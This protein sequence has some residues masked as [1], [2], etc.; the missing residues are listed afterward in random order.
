MTNERMSRQ[1]GFWVVGVLLAVQPAAWAADYGPGGE[2]TVIVPGEIVIGQ[3]LGLEDGAEDTDICLDGGGESINDGSNID[4]VV[5]IDPCGNPEF[6][7]GT[8]WPEWTPKSAG[9]HH[10]QVT[11]DDDGTYYDD[12]PHKMH[13]TINVKSPAG[14][15]AGCGGGSGR[16]GGS[17][18]LGS[19]SMSFDLGTTTDGESAGALWI[20][21]SVPRWELTQPVSVH[22]DVEARDVDVHEYGT[23]GEFQV[24]TPDM[25]ADVV[26]TGT[27]T[28][29][30]RYYAYTDMWDPY[31][32]CWDF[33]EEGP[34]RK[35]VIADV[36]GGGNGQ[37]LHVT[38]YVDNGAGLVQRGK[39]EYTYQGSSSWKLVTKD[40]SANTLQTE[41]ISWTTPD[42][43]DDEDDEGRAIKVRSY[44]RKEGTT[45]VY[46]EDTAYT[47]FTWG[48]RPTK[49][50]VDSSGANLQTIWTY[51]DDEDDGVYLRTEQRPDGSWT[52][53]TLN[54]S[55]GDLVMT[56]TSGWLDKTFPSTVPA[57]GA[58]DVR[59]VELT[60]DDGDDYHL[61]RVK[62]WVAGNVVR[63]AEYTHTV[64][65]LSGLLESTTVERH[66]DDSNDP[67][68]L[69]TVTY[70]VD[71][72]VNKDRVDWIVHPDDRVT[73]PNYDDSISFTAG[74]PPTYT[75][76]GS[77]GY[78]YR[79]VVHGYVDGG[80]QRVTGQSTREVTIVDPAGKP[81]LVESWVWN[82][83]AWVRVDW[84]SYVY[85][86]QDR[87][88]ETHHADG[89][90]ETVN[91]TSCCTKAVTDS[92]GVVT[93]YASDALG[94]PTTI[95]RGPVTTTN[96][97][98][99]AAI[100]T[101][102]DYSTPLEVRVTV[103]EGQPPP[104]QGA[105]TQKTIR[106][107]D[108]AGRLVSVE[109]DNDT[110]DLETMYLYLDPNG[111]NGRQLIVYNDYPPGTGVPAEEDAPD[112][113]NYPRHRI[114]AYY[115]DGQVKSVTGPTV[116]DQHYT[117]SAASGQRSTLVSQVNAVSGTPGTTDRYTK[118]TYDML[119]RVYQE[120]RPGWAPTDSA[121][122][123]TTYHYDSTGSDAGLLKR[124]ER[125]DAADT[126][127]AYDNLSNATYVA[128][129]ADGD[130]TIDYSSD[131][132]VT[133]TVSQYEQLS[134]VWWHVS[135]T[136]VLPNEN[137]SNEV[138]VSEHRRR[139]ATALTGNTIREEVAIDVNENE[140]T[141]TATLH[142]S[143]PIVTETV[144]TPDSTTDA[145]RI[146]VGGRL[147]ESTSSTGVETTYAYDGL[148]RRTDVTDGRNNT[149]TTHYD[150]A[151]RVDW[152]E[153]GDDNRTEY[154]YYGDSAANPG[155]LQSVTIPDV[156][157]STDK[158][159]YYA[160]N[161]RGQITHVWGDVPYPTLTEYDDFGQ[162]YKLTTFRDETLG[163]TGSTWPAGVYN[164]DGDTT[165]WDHDAATG[166]LE[167]K[168][169]ADNEYV[170]YS[171]T[172]VGQIYQ[173][174]WARGTTT[175]YGYNDGTSGRPYTG[176]LISITYSDDTPDVAYGYDRMGRRTWITDGAGKRTLT[177][178]AS[179]LVLDD[180]EFVNAAGSPS[181]FVG[182]II[183]RLYEDGTEPNGLDGRFKGLQ[184]GTTGDP[185]ESY[186]A[187]YGYDAYGRIST[188]HGDGLPTG[189]A[190]YG[191][192]DAGGH[193]ADLVTSLTFK[194]GTTKRF[195]STWGHA[196]NRDLVATVTNTWYD[197][198]GTN[199]QTVSTYSYGYNAR[200]QR[201]Y[202][203]REGAAFSN[204]YYRQYSYNDRGE[205]TD[206]EY[207]QAVHPNTNH[208]ASQDRAYGYDPVGNRETSQGAGAVEKVYA[209]NQL[210]QYHHV[211][212]ATL[213]AGGLKLSYDAD[214]NLVEQL[215]AG[216][217]NCDGRVDWRD[218]DCFVAAQNNCPPDPP[219]Y[220]CDPCSCLNGDLNGDGVVN[221]RD[222]DWYS[223]AQN[224]SGALLFEYDAENR[225][226][227][228]YPLSPSSGSKKIVFSYDYQNRRVRKQVFVHNGSDWPA[229]PSEDWRFVWAGWR[230]LAEID[231]LATGDAPDATRRFVWGLDLAGQLGLLNSM[232][233]AGGIGGLL[234]VCDPNDMNDPADTA[235][236]F[237]YTYDANGNV[238]Q[239]IDRTPTNWNASTVMVARYEYD[240][241]GK[242]TQSAGSY[243]AANPFRFSTKWF[244]DET[245]FGY[246]G[247]R[248]DWPELGRWLNRDPIE[249]AGGWNLYGYVNNNPVDRYDARGLIGDWA[250]PWLPGENPFHP[251]NCPKAKKQ[252]PDCSDCWDTCTSPEGQAALGG[253][254]GGVL[255][256]SDGCACACI[257]NDLF[258]GDDPGSGIARRCALAHEETHVNQV[259]NSS[260]VFCPSVKPGEVKRSKKR[261]SLGCG[262]DWDECEAYQKEIDCLV[263][264]ARE[265]AGDSACI[266]EVFNALNMALSGGCGYEDCGPFTLG[267]L[268]GAGFDDF[269]VGIL[270]DQ[271]G[272][273]RD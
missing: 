92:T 180:E 150:A 41:E 139:V 196:D 106:K 213:S 43:P 172:T 164:T 94:R 3:G 50:V 192:L 224:T 230:L 263:Q 171:Y 24:E 45:V 91:Y 154:A 204:A 104:D 167:T 191:Y 87:L 158:E 159:T 146:Y 113:P 175:T 96:Y 128:T 205:L 209:A 149:T 257:A 116:V 255:C 187:V 40:A 135:K 74:T 76:S 270:E 251:W 114:T 253:D 228:T 49:R 93:T 109:T 148:G 112:E 70:Y 64:H 260:C 65:T 119:G 29:E 258:P 197:G 72:A 185:D 13:F 142:A 30:I 82:G 99:Q 211:R 206:A 155:M 56:E 131:D 27:Y 117:Y 272:C 26:K 215:L 22:Y 202:K 216:D 47:E 193:K 141:T 17:V 151:G 69:E 201:E 121:I 156:G 176:E 137:N 173:R 107:Y 265:C 219:N 110:G 147:V 105:L 189:G 237:V 208:V 162:R 266:R 220:P 240:P 245:G 88:V 130:G 184:V 86:D 120:Q 140:T 66:L 8:D 273:L 28:Y 10:V 81:C 262:G 124:V 256:R 188:V 73:D 239:L 259:H 229:S 34:F 244:D 68:T 21:E 157:A 132:R 89:T 101:S 183:G 195:E 129:D 11:V 212:P 100:T 190:T 194:T 242:V 243:A 16:Y 44:T 58:S 231:A 254:N 71:D 51:V 46:S 84:T 75:R 19:V 39:R 235:G 14:G 200:D 79:E 177:Y 169:Y 252:N 241:Y 123:T 52:W 2:P 203:Q 54:D 108:T 127:Y 61:A 95:V 62:E 165:I 118:S 53:Y 261:N 250:P 97:G 248:Y 18:A 178:D 7:D 210:N 98:N 48:W 225:L 36:G 20:D 12:P 161:A 170:E 152:V 37:Q 67:N 59:S 9:T 78:R 246:W 15:C 111:G 4:E 160:Y 5:I 32:P 186:Y 55:A 90:S 136:W 217:M 174:T 264:G 138:L 238:G 271:A 144:D 115:L 268:R 6:F 214:G 143:E 227:A 31:C 168:T 145:V 134:S 122:L 85:D 221:W 179:T 23:D 35:W 103:H 247:E 33:T 1:L 269:R 223:A 80:F 125:S 218:N 57:K 133:H 233:A 222:I 83:T 163:F 199:P 166:L 102:Y 267:D 153:D 63:E 42:P 77:S 25:I 232:E 126:L 234:A 236:D 249:E 182:T 181:L 38:E 207:H 198:S 60:Y 226:T